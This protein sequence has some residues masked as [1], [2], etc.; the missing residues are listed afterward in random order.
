MREAERRALFALGVGD[1]FAAPE[2]GGHR[3]PRKRRRRNR[4]PIS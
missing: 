1:V 4:R 2:R 3:G